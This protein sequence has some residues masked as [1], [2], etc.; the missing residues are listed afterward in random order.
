VVQAVPTPGQERALLLVLKVVARVAVA[1]AANRTW[2]AVAAQPAAMPAEAI[3]RPPVP[4]ADPA[5]SA[6]PVP[7]PRAA[8]TNTKPP[9]C[10]SGACVQ[11]GH[12]LMTAR[13]QSC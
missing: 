7:E 4:V 2:K 5:R 6:D 13:R 1:A 11:C 3:L 9:E 8:A 10:L 12:P